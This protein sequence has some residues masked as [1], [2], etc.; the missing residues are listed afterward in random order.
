MSAWEDHTRGPYSVR[1]SLKEPDFSTK[2]DVFQRDSHLSCN[3]GRSSSLLRRC[4]SKPYASGWEICVR[5]LGTKE[6]KFAC[7]SHHRQRADTELGGKGEKY[8]EA[9]FL[10]LSEQI[11]C[12]WPLVK[13]CGDRSNHMQ[14][15]LYSTFGQI[16]WRAVFVTLSFSV[17]M[18][19]Q[20]IVSRTISSVLILT[21]VVGNPLVILVVI[22]NR[23]MKT[24]MNYL[25]LNLAA[26]D[27]TAGV[28]LAPSLMLEH[29]TA[30][31]PG[32][33]GEVLCR[34]FT[35]AYLGWAGFSSSALSLV[36]IAFD[37]YYAIM[38]PYSIR[39][40][41]TIKKLK[42]FIPACWIIS[43]ILS[44]PELFVWEFDSRGLVCRLNRQYT[45]MIKVFY[46]SYISITAVCPTGIMLSLYSRLIRRLWFEKANSITFQVV[47]RLRKKITKT[48]IILSAIYVICW[49]PDAV[50]Q[51]LEVHFSSYVSLS[52]RLSK[53]FHCI[54]LLN[55]TVN[56]FIYAFQFRN[57]R[58]ELMKMCCCSR[59]DR[60]SHA[61]P[62]RR[63]QGIEENG[64]VNIG[65]IE[66]V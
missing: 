18:S 28:F 6:Q 2:C 29:T 19:E 42:I 14:T 12:Y 4:V 24:P 36:F 16:I 23:S 11:D 44:F 37:R 54:V 40:R 22:R 17:E 57:F 49:F 41:T 38:K 21:N 61:S 65:M 53:I 56:P 52:S 62:L 35:S 26:A 64:R 25:I 39:H 51:V 46:T 33:T 66:D 63:N 5:K 20:D 60:G 47:R 27:L 32:L 1:S 45:P 34:L 58:R 50:R 3:S 7:C 9:F 55:S 15:R 48:M 30:Y 31:P 59:R 8:L 10:N 13:F 43:A